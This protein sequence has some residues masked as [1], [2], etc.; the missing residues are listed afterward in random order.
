MEKIT[1]LA[2]KIMDE[3]KDAAVEL[4]ALHK[5]CTTFIFTL[6]ASEYPTLVT[7]ASMLNRVKHLKG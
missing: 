3:A 1:N 6:T 4:A 5:H 7:A 2:L